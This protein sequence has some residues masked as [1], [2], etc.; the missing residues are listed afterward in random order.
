M[1][2]V[3][4]FRSSGLFEMSSSLSD[5][6]FSNTYSQECSNLFISELVKL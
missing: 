3:T 6:T 2:C 5:S 1:R 4:E